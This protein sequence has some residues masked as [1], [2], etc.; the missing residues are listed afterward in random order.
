MLW[1]LTNID[2]KSAHTVSKCVPFNKVPDSLVIILECSPCLD[3][4]GAVALSVYLH[5]SES[6]VLQW[7]PCEIS[8]SVYL[9][10]IQMFVTSGC[11]F[12]SLHS[13]PSFSSHVQV[14]LKVHSSRVFKGLILVLLEEQLRKQNLEVRLEPSAS[15]SS[16][17]CQPSDKPSRAEEFIS[18]IFN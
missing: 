18:L 6:F 10:D 3:F 1:N 14:K 8:V 16:H 11:C 2:L 17:C 13:E 7:A 4:H 15:S 12:T 5:R 9:E